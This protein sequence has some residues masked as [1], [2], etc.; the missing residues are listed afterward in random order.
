MLV[1][2]PIAGQVSYFSKHYSS[3]DASQRR[4]AVF[5]TV[6]AL[7]GDAFLFT[8]APGNLWC[9]LLLT[10]TSISG[11]RRKLQRIFR[12]ARGDYAILNTIS[13]P[14]ASEFLCEINAPRYINALENGFFHC[15]RAGK[16][17][18]LNFIVGHLYAKLI[19]FFKRSQFEPSH[20]DAGP[21]TL[22]ETFVISLFAN[23]L[24]AAFA[25]G[26]RLVPA[27]QS[28]FM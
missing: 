24:L 1:K 2:T 17:A 4:I 13:F 6:P 16:T 5:I 8:A 11:K 9:S 23:Q 18:S 14:R 10:R 20:R 27:P 25:S 22:K 3:V 7:A 12:T 21:E 15:V 26:D 28:V 19:V